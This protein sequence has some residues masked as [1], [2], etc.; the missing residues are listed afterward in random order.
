MPSGAPTPLIDRKGCRVL[1]LYHP[2]FQAA[3]TFWWN[4]VLI[5][6][7]LELFRWK[8][9]VAVGKGEQQWYV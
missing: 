6:T 7:E 2:E 9:A 4:G 3:I 8:L 5:I 1:R